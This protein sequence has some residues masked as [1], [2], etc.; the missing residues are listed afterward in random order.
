M[1]VLMINGSPRAK[2]CTF[3]A[4]SEIADQLKREGADSEIVQLGTG[5]LRDCI[6]CHKC[7]ELNNRCIFNDDV[8]NEIIEK[9]E[10]ADGFVFGTPRNMISVQPVFQLYSVVFLG[11]VHVDQTS[12][13]FKAEHI[14][15]HFFHLLFILEL[16]SVI[17]VCW[18]K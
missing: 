12:H 17:P 5:P 8:V 14:L 11:A 15:C 2:G 7:D 16:P 6:A 10:S 18:K 13:R 4:L 1:K 9:A 3:T